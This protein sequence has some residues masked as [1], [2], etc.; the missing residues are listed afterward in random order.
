MFMTSQAIEEKLKN[1]DCTLEELMDEPEVIQEL[2]AGN[3][4]LLEL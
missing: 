1:S 2:K 3:S 4:K